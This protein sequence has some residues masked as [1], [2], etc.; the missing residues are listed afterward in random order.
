VGG[1]TVS[2]A[3]GFT[4]DPDPPLTIAFADADSMRIGV[5][6]D[7]AGRAWEPASASDSVDVSAG[8][9]GPKIVR[10]QLK[11]RAG[12][13]SAWTSDSTV[14]DGTLPLSSVTTNGTFRAPTWPGRIEGTASDA[15]S[16][17]ESVYV[18]IQNLATTSYWNGSAWVASLA[19][20]SAPAATAADG[21]FNTFSEPWSNTTLPTWGNGSSYQVQAQAS[22]G[23]NT[24]D[25]AV[26]LFGI[27]VTP[28][29]PA[30]PTPTPTPTAAPTPTPTPTA[31]PTPT[32]TPSTSGSGTVGTSGGTVATGDGK[33]EITFPAGAFD[34]STTVTITG[35]TCSHGDVD[36]FVVGSTCFSVT[37]SG[38]LGAEAT[39][40]V[41]LS[42]YDLSLGDE[43][44]LTLGYWADGTWNEASDITITGN[45][46]CGKTSDLSD[47][48]VLSS[49]GEG[50][51]WW[52]WALIGGGAFIV[53]LAIILLI[54]LPKRGKGEEI[55]AE[56]LYGEEEEEF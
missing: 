37:P 48:A 10:L 8:G 12:N 16:G 3:G 35:G 55:P 20:G 34:A 54:A 38:A 40:C 33:I 28:T 30:T 32:P 53:V 50:W 23:T 13:L 44:D 19:L 25:S 24:A 42:S 22:D 51:V 31:A 6:S 5:D 21:A 2:D 29:P 9:N 43:G 45:T 4:N 52:Y 47:W 27:G 15:G 7:T 14:Y 39:I 1:V 49:T 56:E 36:E 26:V 41:D 11:D 46:I 17:V 18:Q